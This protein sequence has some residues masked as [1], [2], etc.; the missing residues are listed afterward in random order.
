MLLHTWRFITLVG[1]RE[2]CDPQDRRTERLFRER[3]AFEVEDEGKDDDENS[4]C[5][6][7]LSL[8]DRP[9]LVSPGPGS[10]DQDSWPVK[11]G[12][13]GLP[14]GALVLVQD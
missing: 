14:R 3:G 5:V 4:R 7:F 6:F 9:A 1:P 8:S 11:A 10:H 2:C 13:P 12:V